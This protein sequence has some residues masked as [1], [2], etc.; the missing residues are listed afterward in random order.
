MNELQD[1]IAQQNIPVNPWDFIINLLLT[2]LLSGLLAMAYSRFGTSLSNRQRFAGNFVLLGM[3][4]MVIISIVKSSLA[5][6]LGL[7]GALSIV[8]FRS[9]I[10]DPEEL[11]FLF[12]NI[13]LGLGMGAN[14]RWLTLLAF[15]MIMVAVVVRGV[16]QFRP[17]GQSLYLSFN[18][19]KQSGTELE[20][21]IA[22]LQTHCRTVKLKRLDE[23]PEQLDAA[24]S[25]TFGKVEDFEA[26]RKALL[27]QQPDLQ[28]TFMDDQLV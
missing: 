26:C 1:L 24:F 2:A 22:I 19:P 4:T 7:V 17:S 9:A 14:Q 16:R 12:I 3:T 6:S 10:K 25:L 20:E 21:L 23:M 13:A 28:L 11:T 27:K 8:R 5:L 18:L 15:F